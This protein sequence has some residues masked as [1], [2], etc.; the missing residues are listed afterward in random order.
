[1]K[2]EP[3][4]EFDG[5]GTIYRFGA[6]LTG[7]QP[8]LVIEAHSGQHIT[9]IVLGPADLG[10]FANATEDARKAL[11]RMWMASRP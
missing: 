11:L 6:H 1:M 9:Q 2:I 4:S 3:I 8:E 10:E 7:P 5:D